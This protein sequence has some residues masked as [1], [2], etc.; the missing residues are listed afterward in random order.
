MEVEV[1]ATEHGDPNKLVTQLTLEGASFLMDALLR[2]S[3]AALAELREKRKAMENAA[4][5][6]R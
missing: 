6:G 4:T 2:C 3:D 5:L 1:G